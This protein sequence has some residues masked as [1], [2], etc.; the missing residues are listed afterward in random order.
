MGRRGRGCSNAHPSTRLAVMGGCGVTTRDDSTCAS[1]FEFV[2]ATLERAWHADTAW[3]DDWDATNPARGQ[4][5]S[6]ALV[7]QDLCGGAVIRGLV[8]DASPDGLIVHYWNRL[9]DDDAD[10][11]WQQFSLR[12]RVVSGIEVDRTELLTSRWLV[13]RY[14]TLRDRVELVT[15]VSG[16]PD[17]RS[18]IAGPAFRIGR[19]ER[20]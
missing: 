13:E 7:V 2:A 18:S 12:A 4:C 6:S 15:C 1:L 9:E 11:T 5:G 16:S 10:T 20:G 8:E 19:S 14:E 17:R 3:I